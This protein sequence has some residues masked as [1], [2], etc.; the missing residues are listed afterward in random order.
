MYN[1]GFNS[2]EF[3]GIKNMAGLNASSRGEPSVEEHVGKA[4]DRTD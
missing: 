2:L 3:E 1:P 4:M